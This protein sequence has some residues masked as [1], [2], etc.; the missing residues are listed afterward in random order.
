MPS[1]LRAPVRFAA[2][3]VLVAGLAAPSVAFA[4]CQ[5]PCGIY[6][7][8]LRFEQLLE[9]AKTIAKAQAQLNELLAGGQP[10]AQSVNQM[11]RWVMTKEDHAGKVQDTM[12]AYFLA[13]RIKADSPRYVEQLKAAHVVI[14]SAM[15]CKQSADG[16]TAK[17]LEDAIYDLYRAYEGKEPDFESE[18]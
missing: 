15:K 9:D 6:G 13:Q 1:M 3:A 12:Q 7:D 17:A 8:Q 14:T 4:H 10:T 16:T 2:L 5:V 11:A 18:K